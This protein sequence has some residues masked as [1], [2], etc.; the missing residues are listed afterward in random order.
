MSSCDPLPRP[1]ASPYP[2]DL[3]TTTELRDG[4]VFWLRP[5][6]P[7]D[8]RLLRNMVDRM[9]PEDLR[10]RF[11]V[12]L[13]QLSDQLAA[14]LSRIDYDRE[15]ALVAQF[16]N[17]ESIAGVARY[18][19]DAGLKR[20]ELALV[21]RSD[22]QRRGL[23]VTLLR[24]LIDMAQQ[25]GIVMLVAYVLRENE[26][27]LRLCRAVGFLVTNHADDPAVLKVTLTLRARGNRDR[28]V[29]GGAC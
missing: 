21:V 24:R 11:F 12:P 26:R 2:R 22:C 29:T 28:F 17:D 20:A 23:G 8:D 6:R 27:M 19:A 4:S 3:E 14:R 1:A 25:R 5:V 9:H 13:S 15:L 10:L 18:S 7:E 16:P